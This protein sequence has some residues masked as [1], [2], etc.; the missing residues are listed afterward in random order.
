MALGGD[1]FQARRDGNMSHHDAPRRSVPPKEI[2]MLP[3]GSIAAALGTIALLLVAVGPSTSQPSATTSHAISMFGDL[4]Y[5]PGFK[6]F[7]YVNPA[8]PKGGDVKLAAL[9]T[10]D[11]LNPFILRGVSA[12]GIGLTFETLMVGSFDEPFSEYGLV[13]ESI[14]VPADRTW[15][16][17]TLR[18]QARFHDG[19]A[20][21]VEDV[22]WTFETLKAKGQPFFRAYYAQVAKAEKVGDRKVKFSFGPGENRELP[23]IVGQ[24]PVLSKAYWSKRD[25][26]KTTLDIPLGSGP[27]RVESLEPGRSITYRRVKDHWAAKLPVRVGHDNFDSIRYDYYRDITVAVEALKGG[28]YDFRQENVAKNWATAYQVPA[29]TQGLLKRDE[30]A[31]EVPT[32]MQAFVYNTRRP[33]F[34]DLRVRRALAY[35][36]DFDWMNKNLF[37][38]SYKRTKSYFSN[39][40]LASDGLPGPEELKI[41]EPFRG[42]IPEEVFTQEYVPPDGSNQRESAREALRLLGEAG[43]VVKGQKL[44]NA[45]TGEPMAFEILLSDP[46]WERIALPFAKSLERL[47]I[48]ARVRTVDTAQYQNRTDNFDFDML[49]TVWAQSLSP[50]NEQRDFWG[51]TAATTPGSRNLAG[52]KDPVVDKLIDLVITAPD[53]KSLVTRVH[54]LDRVLLWG[55]YV[56]PQ[57]HINLYRVVYWDKFGRPAVNPKYALG[58]N[59]WWIDAQKEAA[60][61]RGRGEVPKK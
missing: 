32:G 28:A 30:I 54:A 39:S 4:K 44:V 25:F 50:G 57:W 61:A 23:L 14:E 21:T 31:N 33:V 13:A 9:G 38:G 58:F 53:R 19:S 36:F 22:I 37:Y 3:F 43:W 41:L 12:A 16:A 47:G 59:T 46:S 34:Q 8:A 49:V 7:D 40:E 29:V 20:I 52:I 55:S 18:P 56:I 27:Y 5:G 1:W 60:L 10:F 35:A 6:H 26:E 51:S 24:L 15:V 45:K 42:K 11:S 2:S 17:F 48:T